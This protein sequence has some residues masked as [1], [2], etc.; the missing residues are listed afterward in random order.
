MPVKLK[1]SSH[2]NY[3]GYQKKK[4]RQK[5]LKMASMKRLFGKSKSGDK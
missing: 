4:N 3:R 2:V 1:Q 5:K